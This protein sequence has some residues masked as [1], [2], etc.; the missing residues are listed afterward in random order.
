M[1]V[2][3]AKEQPVA[4]FTTLSTAF[5]HKGA[6]RSNAGAGT[7]HDYVTAAIFR[8]AEACIGVDKDRHGI[9]F[10]QAG[11]IVGSHAPTILLVELVMHIG[12][13]Q[14]YF[15]VHL[16]LAGGDGVHAGCQRAQ[17][18]YQLGSAPGGRE[19]FQY[20]QHLMGFQQL[21]Q[22]A[23]TLWAYGCL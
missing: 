13:G 14:M 9:A 4:A 23:Q 16:G 18:L 12:H 10:V 19:A 22:S 15:F 7:N 20:V 21:L 8:Q 17:G 3:V 11:Q 5:L 1:K 2:R 6:E